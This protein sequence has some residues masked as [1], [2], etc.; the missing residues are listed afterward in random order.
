MKTPPHESVTLSRVSPTEIAEIFAALFPSPVAAAAIEIAAGHF[1]LWP[2]EEKAIACAV[3]SRRA[4]FAAGRYCARACLAKLGLAGEAVPVGPDRAPV[5]PAGI[6]GS[7]THSAGHCA[8][9]AC[10]KGALCTIGI[11]MEPE[12]AVKTDLV[13]IIMRPEEEAAWPGGRGADGLD[14]P[15]LFFCLKEAVYK[16]L[17]PRCGRLID[18]QELRVELAPAGRGFRALPLI[19]LSGPVQLAGRYG[20]GQGRIYAAAWVLG[21]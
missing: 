17:Y 14:T 21:F 3:P 16:A 6:T 11:D 12:G 7:I 5:W 2:E 18:F 13:R 4:E 9:V 15:T 1:P 19:E 8:A 10:R 20:M